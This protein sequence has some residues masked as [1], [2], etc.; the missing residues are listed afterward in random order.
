ML[1][2]SKYNNK[3]DK[4]NTRNKV[5]DDLALI[6]RDPEPARK[7]WIWE[8]LQNALDAS[9]GADE[10]L[11]VSIK[12]TPE[13]G[14][15]FQYDGAGFRNDDVAHLIRS[16]TTKA[17]DPETTGHF[18]SGFITTHLLSPKIY[19]SGKIDHPEEVNHGQCFEFCLERKFSSSHEELESLMDKASEEFEASL[20][21]PN[22]GGTTLTSFQ[23]PPIKDDASEADKANEAIKTGIAELKKGASFL[24]AFNKGFSQI[25]FELEGENA[26]FTETNRAPLDSESGMSKITVVTVSEKVNEMSE[27]KCLFLVEDNTTSTSVAVPVQR[28]NGARKC[29]D[30]EDTPRIFRDF[31]LVGTGTFSFPAVINSRQFTPVETRDGVQ[32][33]N[34]DANRKHW[35]VFKSACELLTGLIKYA[36]SNGWSNAYTLA[37]IPKIEP[38]DWFNDSMLRE[39]ISKQFIEEVRRSSVIALENCDCPASPEESTL[40]F[41]HAGDDD[42]NKNNVEVLWGLL[43]NMRE[44][45]EK[46]P[47]KAEAFGWFHAIKSWGNLLPGQHSNIGFDCQKLAEE[48][49]N[50]HEHGNTD[51]RSALNDTLQ[52]QQGVDPIE[53]LNRFHALIDREGL[54]DKVGDCRIVPAQDRQLHKLSELHRDTG[55]SKKLKDIAECLEWPIRGKLRD[56]RINSLDEYPGAGEWSDEYVVKQLIEKLHARSKENPDSVFAKASVEVFRWITGQKNWKLLDNFPAFAEKDH[57]SGAKE[58]VRMQQLQKDAGEYP[59]LAPVRAWQNDLQKYDGLFPKRHIMA[60]AFFSA[61]PDSDVWQHLNEEGFA[62]NCVIIKTTKEDAE[63]IPDDHTKDKGEEKHSPAE[64]I[65]VTNIAFLKKEDIGIMARVPDSQ[66]LARL[67]WRFL[68]DWVFVQEP[69]GLENPPAKC[70]DCDAEHAYPLAE[71]LVP[72]KKN[73]W[74]PVGNRQTALANAESLGA[75][76]Q[77]APDDCPQNTDGLTSLLEAIDVRNPDLFRIGLADPKKQK[78]LVSLL[79][80]GNLNVACEI[81]EDFKDDPELPGYLADRRKQ[82]QTARKNHELGER[83]EELVREIL[84]KEGGFKVDKVRVGADF[85]ITT[86]SEIDDV[87]KFELTSP[88]QSK[89]LVE[90]KSTRR[91]PDGVRMT[92]VQ[93]REASSN[94]ENYLLCV[95]PLDGDEPEM[96]VVRENMR[97][98]QNIGDDVAKLVRDFDE[99][100]NRR[101]NIT[102]DKDQDVQLSI[103]PGMERILVKNSVWEKE[104]FPLTQLAQKLKS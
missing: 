31:P 68:V 9:R 88:S 75:L 32:F 67:F 46:L 100:K 69:Q 24:V 22:G 16:G 49:H 23:Y 98:V 41:S 7:R 63:P 13:E 39:K 64:S 60:D 40:P 56:G 76:F 55:V 59:Y 61:V 58:I 87:T 34:A 89:W 10:G 53:W 11:H 72:V 14:L 1:D 102:A 90:V 66:R 12:H 18:G 101:D 96:E 54:R 4:T 28:I 71:W 27:E 82:K 44:K 36:V 74:V 17:G 62:K 92:L 78:A 79:N 77:N 8:L 52:L 33:N 93:A 94:K 25:D 47:K 45:R 15:V 99:F 103:S 65:T 86:D 37:D 95:V 30:V 48:I 35:E 20:Q 97:F 43:N 42:H 5:Y 19:V 81:A 85:E 38:R 70:A 26:S 2:F 84:E 3:A 21:K 50:A 57:N 80:S 6:Q 104:G 29:L 91:G 51:K 83:V 73:Q